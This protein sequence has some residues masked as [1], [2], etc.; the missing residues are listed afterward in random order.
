[1]F[2]GEQQF[3]TGGSRVVLFVQAPGTQERSVMLR[4]VYRMDE[5]EFKRY[6]IAKTFATTWRRGRR[7]SRRARSRGG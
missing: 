5:T 7:S 6:W 3:W 4:R 2:L 1:V